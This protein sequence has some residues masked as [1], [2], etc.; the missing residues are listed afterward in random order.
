M[1]GAIEGL[2]HELRAVGIPVSVS[3]LIDA[4]SALKHLD[5]ADR[6]SVKTSLAS[7]LI[8]DSSHQA[9]YDVVF[10]L[11]FSAPGAALATDEVHD[12][13]ARLVDNPSVATGRYGAEGGGGL[14]HALNDDEL[15]ALTL[16]VLRS[17]DGLL[18]RALAAEAVTRYAGI[19]PG[20][21][22][23]GTY[24]LVRTLRSL[25]LDGALAAVV[26]ADTAEALSPLDRRLV[27]ERY[28][29]RILEMRQAIESDI[30]RRLVSDRDAASVARTLRAP[31]PEDVSF[32]TASQQQIAE[33]R[34]V[35]PKLASKLTA[36]ISDKR[37]RQRDGRLDFRRTVRSSM[38]TGGVP[39]EPV[40][41]KA[42]PSKPELI[43]LADIS[44]SVA[45]FAGFT[46][47]L[48][49]AL[50]SQFRRV[51]SFVFVDGVDEVTDLLESA[52]RITDVTCSINAEG[53]GVWLDGRSDYGHAL[54]TFWEAHGHQVTSRSTVLMLGDARSNYHDPR[55]DRLRAIARRAGSVFWLN[56]EA[57]GS[58]G[59]GDSVMPVYAAECAG[60][61][62]C[63]NLRQLKHFVENLP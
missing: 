25:G 12:G 41:H 31:L 52:T 4:V 21:P 28:E 51:R 50:R 14:F 32:L 37:T 47:Q 34:E 62:E 54:D 43:V 49:F 17:N 26:A 58:W 18:D 45:T 44:G 60:A 6:V 56:P 22:V 5:I 55:P 7:I 11:F 38:S 48:A 42:R 29:Q 59:T 9:T 63:R 30:R 19:A 35:L 2:V 33:L 10:D 1:I 15:R 13:G 39:V 20:R 46:L 8:K 3:E 57:E 61:Y 53:L 40:F 24:Y 16:S 23:A 27:I 36:A